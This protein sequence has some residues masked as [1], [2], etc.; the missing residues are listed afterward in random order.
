MIIDLVV[1]DHDLVGA[2]SDGFLNSLVAVV[3]DD[4]SDGLTALD[5]SQT[6]AGVQQL[7]ANVSGLAVFGF[8]KDPQVLSLCFVASL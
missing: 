4:Q 6:T 2:V 1:Q 8:N 7:Q 3:A 5:A